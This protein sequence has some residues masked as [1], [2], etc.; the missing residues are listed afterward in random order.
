VPRVIVTTGKTEQS[1]S[2]VLLD[3]T[4]ASLHLASEHSAKQF[5]ERLGWAISDAEERERAPEPTWRS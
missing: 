1:R 4:V 3:E 5:V 2:D